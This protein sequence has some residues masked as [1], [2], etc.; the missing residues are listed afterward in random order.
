MSQ[1][2]TMARYRP[3]TF[4]VTRAT[5]RDGAQGTHYLRADQDLPPFPE[6][7][8]D[9]LVHWAKTRPDQT[10]FARRTK[11]ADGS[12]GDW[13]HITFAQAL[14]AARRIGQGLINRG[15]STERPVLIL[16]ENDLE[17]ALLALGCVYA[18][19][20]YCPTS[21]AYSLVSQDFDKLHH[22]VKT[23]TPGLVFA[24]DAQR[25]SRAMLATLGDGVELV[26]TEGTVPGRATTAFADLLATEATP[27]VDAAMAATGADTIV[28]FL[29]TSGSTKMPKAVINTQRMWCANQQ[30]MMA[31]MPVLAESPLVLVDWLPWNHTFGGN[32]NVGM[33]LF[34]GG[35][36]FIDDGKPTPALMG[37]TLRNLREIAPTV[38]FNV[39]TGFEAIANAMKTDEALRKTLL[40]RVRMFFYAGAALAQPVWDA[41][42]A[43][44]EAEI[45]ERVVM[46]TGLGMT[47]SS[48][49]G[50]FV[51]SPDVK[52]G[53]LGLPTPGLELKLVDTDGKTEVRYKGPN[54]TPG[55]WRMPAETAE[56]FDEE[57]FFKTGDAVKWIDETDIHQGL[58][59]DG[60]IA[61]DFK[62]ATGTFVSVGPLRA[63]IIAAGAPY[64]Q[65]V[66]ITGLNMKEVGAM[67]FPTPLVRTLAGMPSEAPM[68]DVLNSE[69][70]LAHFQRV[71]TEL[72]KTSTGSASRIARLCLLADP[73]TIDRGEVTDK[74][75]INQRAVLAHRAETVERLH[76]DT[77]HAIL[78]PQ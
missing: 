69:P 78:K 56:A 15:L 14:D 47:E 38:Y 61:E 16:S 44:Q 60:R 20:A 63:K 30:Q 62:L 2:P 13:R 42:H 7:I 71:V 77:L 75:S 68:H 59:F 18:G 6:R 67:V 1:N 28:K 33:V 31:S 32:H 23:L 26:T 11:N 29:F 65:D 73:P 35:T 8:T 51:T 43:V 72:A 22:V 17:H 50:I 39:P 58:K 70:V 49:F 34:H 10:V 41:L 54:I 25:Y 64:I 24:S 76:A 66:V 46:G 36:L 19:I 21:P 74:G 53:D 5:L 27:A 45:G 4:G 12:T 48:P 52:A 55:Y 37:E 9:R 40:S 3:L 57:G